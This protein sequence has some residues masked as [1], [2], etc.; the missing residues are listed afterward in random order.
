LE[1][2]WGS[3]EVVVRLLEMICRREGIGDL[4]AEGAKIAAEKLGR[5]A[6][7]FAMHVGGEMIPMHDPRET[8]GWGAIYVCDPTPG[9]HTRGGTALVESGRG[10]PDVLDAL[11]LPRELEKFNPEGKGRVHAPLAG[12]QHIIHTSGLCL[13]VSD[14]LGY[15][16][17]EMMRAV[18]GWDLTYDE[19][20]TTGLRIATLQ[21]AFNLREGFKPSDFM[22]PARISGKPPF[23]V[24]PFKDLTLDFE[25][26]K[27]QFYEAMKFDY[28]TGAIQQ[29]RIAELGLQDV[30]G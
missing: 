3:A 21:H 26:L 19:L 29:E 20:A 27:R 8:P 4:L 18:T 2:K 7:Q 13:F 22:M 17:V 11:G 12:W 1:L 15:P 16:M 10:T 5:G 30:L 6:E 9:R 14:S 25:E 24:G 28:V 23:K